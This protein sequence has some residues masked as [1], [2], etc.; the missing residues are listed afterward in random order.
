MSS[1]KDC[2]HQLEF[3]CGTS[4]DDD[5]SGMDAHW[6][7]ISYMLLSWKIS[8]LSLLGVKRSPTLLLLNSYFGKP[9]PLTSKTLPLHISPPRIVSYLFNDA[10]QNMA[11]NLSVGYGEG[12]QHTSL[13]PIEKS[14]WRNYLAHYLSL[15]IIIIFHSMYIGHG[16]ITSQK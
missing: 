2:G 1:F 5:Y 16:D 11:M 7:T 10:Y 4:P 8:W 13:P 6:Q 14:D 12:S 9:L 3:P 15:Y